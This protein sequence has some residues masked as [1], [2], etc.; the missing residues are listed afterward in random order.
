GT[1]DRRGREQH[2]DRALLRGPG[3][4]PA[5]RPHPRVSAERPQLGA[6]DRGPARRWV[7]GH[8]L[9][10][11]RL[12]PVVEGRDRLRLRHVRRR[13]EHPDGDARPPERDPRR[14]LDGYGRGR[15]LRLPIR[16]RPGSEARVPRIA[17]AL[18]RGARRQPRGTAAEG[19]RR[20]RSRGEK[21]PLRLVHPV[22]LR[23]LQ[24]RGE[25]RQPHQPGGGQRQLERRH[26]QRSRGGLR[27]RLLLDRGLSRRRRGGPRKRQ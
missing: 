18:P 3:C 8:H 6:A 12:R 9:R 25:P 24:P 4:R 15:P 27:R 1:P 2:P 20:H 5:R 11:T 14:V 10:P 21:R 13:P 22:L 26:L 7:P 23:L 19:L 17:R 16:L